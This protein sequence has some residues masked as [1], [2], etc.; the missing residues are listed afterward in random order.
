MMPGTASFE[1]DFYKLS[2]E[3]SE[4][5]SSLSN[6]S[7]EGPMHAREFEDVKSA[8]SLCCEGI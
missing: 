7:L 6:F 2:Y 3:K 1:S 8:S 5:R 4:Y